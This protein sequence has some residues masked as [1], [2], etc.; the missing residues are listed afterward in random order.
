MRY[1][2]CV[3]T[4]NKREV[5]NNRRYQ[6]QRGQVGIACKHQAGAT[7]EGCAKRVRC[8]LSLGKEQDKNGITELRVTGQGL[9]LQL[10]ER[11]CYYR[12]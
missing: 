9:A 3:T 7:A 1:R 2:S 4:G 8:Q 10:E 11:K 6:Q 12:T 5:D